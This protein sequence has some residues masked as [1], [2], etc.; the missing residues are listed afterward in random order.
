MSWTKN[1]P[2]LMTVLAYARVARVRMEEI[3][4]DE[5]DLPGR[6]SGSRNPY[7]EKAIACELPL[8][9]PFRYW[10]AQVKM[11]DILVKSIAKLFAESYKPYNFGAFGKPTPCDALS[12]HEAANLLMQWKQ[13]RHHCCRHLQG[14]ERELLPHRFQWSSLPAYTWQPLRGGFGGF[15]GL[16]D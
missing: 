6:L 2:S 8:Q 11:N 9:H 3:V 7:L 5:L 1:E 4:D 10:T 13:H 12:A 14:F 15:P 16:R